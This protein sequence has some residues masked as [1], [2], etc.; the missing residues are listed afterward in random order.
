MGLHPQLRD[1]PDCFTSGED[2][3]LAKPIL[4]QEPFEENHVAK[5]VRREHGG[6]PVNGQVQRLRSNDTS[7]HDQRVDG[8]VDGGK[9]GTDR[10]QIG[11]V[12]DN[13]VEDAP[14]GRGFEIGLR[15]C[16]LVSVP[17]RQVDAGGLGT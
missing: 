1:T 12:H 14:A 10:I 2:R 17:A 5:D 11:D 16:R 6:D 15:R 3:N 8:S 13:D 9:A 4:G 7:V